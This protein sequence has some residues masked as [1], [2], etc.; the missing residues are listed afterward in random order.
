L[1]EADIIAVAGEASSNCVA[2]T[3]RDIISCFNNDAY[4]SKIVFLKDCSSPVP[5]FENQEDKFIAEA[6]AKGMQVTT[7]KDF[8]A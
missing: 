6:T 5:G 2:N 3:L 4:V 1:L 7:S 8:L